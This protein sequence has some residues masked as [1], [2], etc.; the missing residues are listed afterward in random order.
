MGGQT[1]LNLTIDCDKAGIWEKYDVQMIGVN[2]DAIETTED[3]NKFV[4]K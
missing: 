2:I 4:V 1:A 3:R